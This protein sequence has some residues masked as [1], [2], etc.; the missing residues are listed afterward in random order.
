M[1]EITEAM[2]EAAA[3]A[4][5]AMTADQIG[6]AGSSYSA[7][8]EASKGK[9]RICARAALEAALSANTVAPELGALLERAESRARSLRL[10][11]RGFDAKLIED[12]SAA[13]I[14]MGER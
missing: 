1:N 2:V 9:V 4:F 13:L 8:P 5:F 14:H 6:K 7:L 3:S 11:N 10:D 12:L